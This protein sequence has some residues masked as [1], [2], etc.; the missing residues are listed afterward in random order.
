MF[1]TLI[2]QPIFNL[3]V[4]IYGL[5]PGHD[6][7]LSIILF[8]VTIRL[9]MWPLV[10]KQLHHSRAMR[11][12]QPEIKKIRAKTKGDKQKEAA[13][14]MELY[15]ERE[16]S[17]FSSLGVLVV[18]LPIL[19]GLFQSLRRM[20]DH[21]VESID[22][23]GY[24]FVKDLPFIQEIINDTTHFS[25]S[26]IDP[27]FIDLGRR[28]I[29]DGVVYIPLMIIAVCAGIVQFFQTRQM[30]PDEG[31][32]RSLRDILKGESKGEQ[33]DQSEINAAMGRNMQYFFPILTVVFAAT[34]PGALALYWL[35]GGLVAV[36]QQRYILQKDAQE[37]TSV[38]VKE[39]DKI[40][41]EAKSKKKEADSVPNK[42]AK[43][44]KAQKKTS[45]KKSKKKKG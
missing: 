39:S 6:F 34:F 14:L 13:L 24:G 36:L 2:I 38:A 17:P 41:V 44:T 42:Q 11:A 8:T 43:K 15:K 27:G 26:L 21:G 29:E 20:A 31:S 18:Q 12:L 4:L 32:A 28:A 40:S 10:R 1:T 22:Q 25:Q 19:I 23:L 45:P 3:L 16:V 37:M 35:A 9:I 30:L 33:A 7:G 5:L